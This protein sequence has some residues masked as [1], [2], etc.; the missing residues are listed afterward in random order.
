MFIAII[1]DQ[2]SKFIV[3]KYVEPYTI[4]YS[5]FGDFINLHLVYNLGAAFS[6]GA[7]FT[8]I[9]RLFFLCILPIV[10]LILLIFVYF[11]TDEF[12]QPQR[13]FV[14]GIIGGGF[15]NIIDRCLRADGV[16]DFI[17]VKFFGLFGLERFPIFN[18]A[19]SFVVCCCIGFGITLI[20]QSIK[21]KKENNS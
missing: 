10:F 20:L 19:D 3:V 16:V 2:L 18:L 8:A 1:A 13:W 15:G 9:P 21:H 6:L 11:K 7:G 17:D 12:T 14:C 4:A 5:F